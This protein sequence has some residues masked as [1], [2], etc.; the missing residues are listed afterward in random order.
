[1]K[2]HLNAD[3]AFVSCSTIRFESGYDFSTD[4][5]LNRMVIHIEIGD[6]LI[7]VEIQTEVRIEIWIWFSMEIHVGTQIWILAQLQIKLW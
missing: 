4:N 1:M 5:C 6:N 3:N 2:I 7:S